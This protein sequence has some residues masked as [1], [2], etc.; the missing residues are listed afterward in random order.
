MQSLRKLVAIV[1]PAEWC[2]VLAVCPS[3]CWEGPAH[4][5]CARTPLDTG[6]RPRL[7]IP[8]SHPDPGSIW[9]LAHPTRAGPSQHFLSYTVTPVC[10]NHNWWR[11][12]QEAEMS[13]SSFVSA[14]VLT[15]FPIMYCIYTCE[16][17][18]CVHVFVWWTCLS[19]CTQLLLLAPT[20]AH[21]KNMYPKLQVNNNAVLSTLYLSCIYLY[22]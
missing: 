2:R 22:H 3:L 8:T 15:R 1:I 17:C 20:A 12:P 16:T 9:V 11:L 5:G 21:L 13:K 14:S 18:M 10:V 19:S 7:W 6:S 4:A